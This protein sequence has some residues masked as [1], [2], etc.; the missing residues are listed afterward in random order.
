MPEM[1]KQWLS[2]EELSEFSELLEYGLD[3]DRT[4]GADLIRQFKELRDSQLKWESLSDVMVKDA[5]R[6]DDLEEV[7]DKVRIAIRRTLKRFGA[8]PCDEM[9]ELRELH[10]LLRW[11]YN[12]K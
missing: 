11:Q 4:I 7:L 2:D 5:S 10:R 6:I 1:R 8:V 12:S 9:Q 3:R